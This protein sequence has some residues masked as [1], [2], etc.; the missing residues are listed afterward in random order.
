MANVLYMIRKAQAP[1]LAEEPERW[2][3]AKF[4][5]FISLKKALFV[6]IVADRLNVKNLKWIAAEG[7]VNIYHE[8]QQ[9]M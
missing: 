6:N 4:Y 8:R 2:S 3:C 5:L 9:S 1:V 7:T